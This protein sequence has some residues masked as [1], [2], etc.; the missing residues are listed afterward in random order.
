[1]LESATVLRSP[2]KEQ[3][4]ADYVDTKMGTAHSRW[5]IAP[6]PWMP[7]SMV[8]LSPDNQ[9]RGWQAGY[10]P[11]F[12]TVGCFSHIH[13]WTMAGL[14]MMPTNGKL[15]TRVGDQFSPDEGYRSR[16]EKRTEEAPLGYYKVFLTDTQIEVEATATER[17]SFQRYIFPQDKDGRVMIDLHIQAEYDYKLFDVDVNKVSDNRIEGHCR[18]ISSR[19]WGKDAEQEYVVNFV[20]EFDAPIKK[21]G[22]WK[23]EEILDTSHISG[24]ELSDAGLFVEFDTKKSPIVQ[25]RTGLSYVSI[26]NASENLN[27]EISERFGWNFEAVVKYQKDV[28]N[29]FLTE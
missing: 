2:Q 25:V 7:F 16:I 9:N 24:E 4:L 15:Y 29:S 26:S 27:K 18:Q 3:T 11:T 14:G 22:G 12:E 21:V 6:G 20:I 17:A 28:W 13:E 5:M 19:I 23:N 10:Q 8:K 1:M